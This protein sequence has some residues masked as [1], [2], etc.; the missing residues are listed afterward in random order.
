MDTYRFDPRETLLDMWEKTK[1]CNQGKHR[2]KQLKNASLFISDDG[3]LGREALVILT[4]LSRL[5]VAKTD[6]PILHMQGWINGQILIAVSRSYSHIICRYQPPSPLR[7]RYPD[8]ESAS[9]QGLAQ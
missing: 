3:M 9:G 7:D 8:W 1:K 6:E 4:N 5:M 2:H